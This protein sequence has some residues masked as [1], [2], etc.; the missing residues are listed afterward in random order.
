M[1]REVEWPGGGD[2]DYVLVAVGLHSPV[3]VATAASERQAAPAPGGSRGGGAGWF[4]WRSAGARARHRSARV[5]PAEPR[6][7]SSRST[8]FGSPRPARVVDLFR[9]GV[10]AKIGRA[11]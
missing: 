3:L 1:G 9:P 4:G 8:R 11:S 6:R 2:G 5:W 10:R 7:R